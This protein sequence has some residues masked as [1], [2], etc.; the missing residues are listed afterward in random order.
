MKQR[1]LLILALAMPMVAHAAENADT[2]S[3]SDRAAI[4]TLES[5]WL[6][7]FVNKDEAKLLSVISPDC[8]LV[9]SQGNRATRESMIADVK[10]G[11]YIVQSAHTDNIQVRVVG[12]WAIVLGLETETSQT[13]GRDSSGQFRFLDT[14]Q[15]R[16]GRWLCVASAAT[17]VKS[18][19]E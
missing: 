18:G 8:W 15:K 19:K 9:D 17:Q 14:W 1:F 3:A 16:D 7:A 12:D 13:N 10:S 2:P 6:K 4:T 5:E 11:A